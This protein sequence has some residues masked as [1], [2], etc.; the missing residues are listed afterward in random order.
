[1]NSIERKSLCREK[2]YTYLHRKADTNEIFYIGKGFKSRAWS[3]K[4]RSDWWVKTS[5]KHG[6]VVEICAHWDSDQEAF[7]HE[8]F[9]IGVFRSLG[10]NLINQTDGGD[11]VKGLKHSQKNIEAARKR[12]LELWASPSYRAKTSASQASRWTC[13]EIERHSERL[14]EAWNDE[15][16]AKHSARLKE[17]YSTPERSAIQRAKSPLVSNRA[18]FEEKRKSGLKSYWLSEE[19]QSEEA[20][21]KRSNAIKKGWATR[22]GKVNADHK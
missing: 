9:L 6:F 22:K 3:S 5:K 10:C 19:S 2:H 4:S 20:K 7:D 11:G 8:V 16:R 15:V 14:K 18:A 17:A 21:I 12:S 13:E 1:M